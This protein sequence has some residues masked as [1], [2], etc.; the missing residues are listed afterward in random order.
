M[1][2]KNVKDPE[3]VVRKSKTTHTADAFVG[4]AA[5][6]VVTLSQPRKN[7]EKP[8]VPSSKT[9][10]NRKKTQSNLVKPSQTQ[11]NPVKPNKNPVKTQENLVKTRYNAGKPMKTR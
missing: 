6:P 2:N 3:N 1:E 9:V 4:G 10:K 11:S 7:P 8:T 5:P